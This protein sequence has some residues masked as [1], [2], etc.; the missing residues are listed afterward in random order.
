V[1]RQATG[2][3]PRARRVMSENGPYVI[4]ALLPIVFAAVMSV[5]ALGLLRHAEP[6]T[7]TCTRIDTLKGTTR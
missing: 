4:Y 3:D 6:R 7:L 1:T 5:L 2:E